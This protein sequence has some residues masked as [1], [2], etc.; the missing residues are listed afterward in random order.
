VDVHN[1]RTGDDF[2][3]G[4]KEIALPDGTTRP[5]SMWLS[6][7]YPRALDGLCKLLSLDM[8]VVDPAWVG[9]KL[10]KLL[11]FP[12]P[13]GDFLAFV[14]G[15]RK[16]QSYPSTVSYLARLILHRYAMLGLLDENGAPLQKMGILEAP[17]P[18]GAPVMRGLKCPECGSRAL[19]RKDGCDWC[20]SCGYTGICG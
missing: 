16:Q 6:G 14:P 1:P 13:L 11:D 5:Y 17:A 3:L 10:K 20:S 9:M 12:E 4:L 19:I 2:V 7:E 8:R 15:S 18:G